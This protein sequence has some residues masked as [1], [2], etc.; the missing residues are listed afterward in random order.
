M[1]HGSNP[2]KLVPDTASHPLRFYILHGLGS[3]FL[4][5]LRRTRIKSEITGLEME[6]CRWPEG[7][8]T[9]LQ[10]LLEGSP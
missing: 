5:E 3:L 1:G 2:S 4:I 8:G 6:A 10:S 7:L 9:P